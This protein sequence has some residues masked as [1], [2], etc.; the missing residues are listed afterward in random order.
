MTKKYE[1]KKI[2]KEKVK[3][4]GGVYNKIFF[5]FSEKYEIWLTATEQ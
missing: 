5:Y 4:N 2:R 1:K 3:K